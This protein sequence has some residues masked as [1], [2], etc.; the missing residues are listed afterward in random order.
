MNVLRP[1]VNMYTIE[2]HFE[3]KK[4]SR[5]VDPGFIMLKYTHC[6]RTGLS[7]NLSESPYVVS[8]LTVIPLLFSHTSV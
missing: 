8:Y 6:M 2:F 1:N 3:Q 7:I 5:P 4:L